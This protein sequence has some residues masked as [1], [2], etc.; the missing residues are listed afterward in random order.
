MK[1]CRYTAF[2]KERV[3]NA[4]HNR[5][6][7][8]PAADAALPTRPRNGLLPGLIQKQGKTLLGALLGRAPEHG[9]FVFDVYVYG[10]VLLG[11]W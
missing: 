11:A 4:C 5:F 7:E 8:I 10:Q 9:L 6:V 3:Q 2:V 1:A